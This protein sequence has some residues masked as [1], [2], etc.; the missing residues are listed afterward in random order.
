MRNP[1]ILITTLFLWASTAFTSTSWIQD[2]PKTQVQLIATS[3]IPE[4]DLKF[5]T[6]VEDGYLLFSSSLSPQ[7]RKRIYVHVKSGRMTIPGVGAAPLEVTGD[8][9]LWRT[10]TEEASFSKQGTVRITRLTSGCELEWDFRVRSRD[11]RLVSEVGRMAYPCS[12]GTPATLLS[13][14]PVKLL[15]PPEEGRHPSQNPRAP[16]PLTAGP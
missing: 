1:M 16:A 14:T 7:W 8:G 6:D 12:T 15:P 11:Q 2:W 13:Q 9:Y 10:T 5:L 3:V 4:K